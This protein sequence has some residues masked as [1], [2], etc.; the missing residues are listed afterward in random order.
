MNQLNC[1]HCGFTLEAPPDAFEGGA[2]IRCGSCGRDVLLRAGEDLVGTAVI[3]PE[4]TSDVSRPRRR[5][6]KNGFSTMFQPRILLDDRER[7]LDRPAPGETQGLDQPDER[8]EL[9]PPSRR[10]YLLRVGA[11]RGSE[12]LAIPSAQTV[13]GREAADVDL[14]DPAVSVR[15]FQIESIGE[16]FFVRDLASRNGTYLNGQKIRYA[17][18]RP[19]DE[20]RAG[21]TVFVFRTE[22]DGLGGAG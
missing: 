22:D 18:L 12:R 13:L 7:T 20:L 11:R 10:A 16:E 17:E 3:D 9:P 19:G 5:G 8:P 2:R 4:A 6:A 15:H 1:P 14:G 21:R